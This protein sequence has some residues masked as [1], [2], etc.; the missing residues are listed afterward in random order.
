MCCCSARDVVLF[1]LYRAAHP[2]E[3][4]SKAA[5][6]RG[7]S[8]LSN[9][10]LFQ[11]NTSTSI[12]KNSRLLARRSRSASR[13]R[14]A[15]SASTSLAACSSTATCAC[16]FRRWPRSFREQSASALRAGATCRPCSASKGLAKSPTTPPPRRPGASPKRRF[17][18]CSLSASISTSGKSRRWPC[19]LD[20]RCS[21]F[22]FPPPPLGGLPRLD[23]HYPF[24]PCRIAAFHSLSRFENFRFGLSVLC[25]VDL[26]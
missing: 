6:E 9:F 24:S 8:N 16:S 7:E 19:K 2:C 10:S 25:L 21:F 11:L 17:A 5:A 15:S 13:P 3:M 26:G 18:R 1:Y 22:F 12:Q 14:S 20:K 23:S 4:R